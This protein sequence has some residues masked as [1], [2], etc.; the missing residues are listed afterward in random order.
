MHQQL[1]GH[2][3]LEI[4]FGR[5]NQIGPQ[6]ALVVGLGIHEVVQLPRRVEKL[7]GT[8][9]QDGALEALAGLKGALDDGPRAQ[10]A[11]L[12][13]HLGAATAHLDVLKLEHCP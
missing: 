6:C 5:A 1:D 3:I 10:V 13:A 8:P 7:D 11:Q 12:Q 4:V 9:L 2:A